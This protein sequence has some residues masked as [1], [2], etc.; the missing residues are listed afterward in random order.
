[1]SYYKPEDYVNYRL[2]RA[3]ETIREVESHIENRF[4]NTALNRMYYAC[5]YAISALLARHEIRVASHQGLRLKFGEHFIKTGIFDKE[6]E[7]SLP[8][9]LINGAKVIMTIF[10][11]MTKKQS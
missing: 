2:Q 6:L 1:M 8:N 5:F 3:R 7:S 9:F 11:I 4:W 10:S